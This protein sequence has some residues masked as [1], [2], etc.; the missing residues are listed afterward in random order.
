MKKF[1]KI[2]V[3]VFVAAIAFTAIGCHKKTSAATYTVNFET[4]GGSTV[5]SYKLEAGSTIN[6]PSTQPTKEMFRFDDWYADENYTMLFQFGTKMPKYDITI[7]AKWAA[8]HSVRIDY[9]ANG[10]EF[11]TAG[12]VFVIGDVGAAYTATTVKPTR[13]GYDFAG[14]YTEPDCFTEATFATYP[15]ENITLYAGWNKSSD[16]VYVSYYGNDELLLVE[17]VRKTENVTEPELFDAGIVCT[18][19]Y[20]DEALSNGYTFGAKEAADISLYTCCYTKGLVISNGVVTAYNGSATEVVVPAKFDGKIVYAIGNTA[21]YRPNSL[22]TKVTLPSTVREI[23]NNAF[24]DCNYLVEV[25]LSSAV[26]SIGD[27]AFCKNTRLKT[28]GDISMVTSIGSGAFLGCES[29]ST[30]EMPSRLVSLGTE[31][32]SDCKMLR[33]V[34]FS[35]GLT[36]LPDNLFEGCSLLESVELTSQYL[37]KIG[38]GVFK[39]CASL[40]SVTI[41]RTSGAVEI[42][43]NAF[44]NSFDVAIYVPQ[45]LLETYQNAPANAAI[46]DKFSV[47]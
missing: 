17:P 22:I 31:A 44:E 35:A 47:R 7:Y 13:Y 4:K 21:F 11:A 26:V 40:K 29:L 32:F 34:T 19:W 8:D 1:A 14:W 27:N 16:F 10:G 28:V 42:A 36:E 15:I 30:F 18:G 20:T 46:Q 3:C 38:A 39:N 9:D 24:Y 12:D 37:A 2:L 23:G 45:S 33:S 43:A 5:A 41:S 6:R 25:N